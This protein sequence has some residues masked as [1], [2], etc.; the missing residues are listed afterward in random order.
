MGRDSGIK[1][2]KHTFNKWV[3]CTKVS[4]GCAN[5]YAEVWARDNK[6]I[7]WGLGQPRRLT[8]TH[9]QNNPFRWE[10]EAAKTGERTFVFSAS[11]SDWLDPEVPAEW[12]A[13]LLDTVVK[14][15]RLTW[16]LL[17]KRP[18]LWRER[19]HAC[20]LVEGVNPAI[21][22]WLDG[23]PPANVWVGTTVEDQAR[24]DLR[25]PALE[26]IPAVLR[27]LS[28]EP[29]IG[30][31]DLN[32]MRDYAGDPSV[33]GGTYPVPTGEIGWVIIGGESGDNAR[34]F[35]L[36]WARS[37]VRQCQEAGV[38]VFVKQYGD[39]PVDGGVAVPITS[40][41]GGNQ[42]EWEPELRVREFPAEK[43][44]ESGDWDY[45]LA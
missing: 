44:P 16:Q 40:D 23:K 13:G 31:V 6:D 14:T 8:S 20:L 38:P 32:L 37:L 36:E 43:F 1:W 30:G 45:E 28:C 42:D 27:F 4:P 34:P 5:C 7:R 3:G 25:I 17:S 9:N 15:P 41:A 26:A 22:D 35:A 19:M 12:L 10:R 11:L 39:R 21:K 2:T 29:L 18:E 24:A 33:P